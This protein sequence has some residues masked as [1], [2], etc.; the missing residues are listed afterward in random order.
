MIV[1]GRYSDHRDNSIVGLLEMV[2]EKQRGARMTQN[3]WSKPLQEQGRHLL[4][5]GRVEN[6]QL[7]L[8]RGDAKKKEALQEEITLE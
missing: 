1:F 5:W 2:C 4:R 7:Y 6:G 3:F 8:S